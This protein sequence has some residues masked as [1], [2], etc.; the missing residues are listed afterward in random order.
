MNE[1]NVDK[2]VTCNDEQKKIKSNKTKCVNYIW[3]VSIVE[4]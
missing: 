3:I 4:I 2:T 1:Q